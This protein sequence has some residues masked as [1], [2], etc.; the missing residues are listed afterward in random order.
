MKLFCGGMFFSVF[1][2]A[3]SS[4]QAADEPFWKKNC[5]QDETGKSHCVVEQY[6]IA[7]P[8]KVPVMRVRFGK[9]GKDDQ[10]GLSLNTPLGV[11]LIP[12]LSLSM[13]GAKPIAL[14]FERCDAQ[15]CIAQAVLDKSAGDKFAKGKTL[16]VHYVLN[17]KQPLDVPIRLEGLAEALKGL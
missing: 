16:V 3:M 1:I 13:D 7:M 2:L 14:P 6:A 11:Q 17:E 12:G 4:A 9:I 5:G 15:G 8:Q 10:L